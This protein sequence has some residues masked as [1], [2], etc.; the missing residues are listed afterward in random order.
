MRLPER[1]RA[2]L[3]DDSAAPQP[4]AIFRIGLALVALVQV[5]VLWVYRDLL[6]AEFGV[7]PWLIGDR[8]T[9]PWLPKI[10]QIHAVLASFGFASDTTVAALL[11]VHAI[12][13]ALLLAGYKTRA[14][15]L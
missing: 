6:L 4:L 7:V 10:S 1:I 11:L 15:A 14:A 2:A 8:M 5:A 3:F 9:D 12:S 13:A